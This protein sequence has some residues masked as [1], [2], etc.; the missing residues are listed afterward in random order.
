MS[1]GLYRHELELRNVPRFRVMEYLVE[2]GGVVEDDLAVRGVDWRAYLEAM[3]PV[4]IT[5]IEVRRDR[6]IIEGTNR[7]K[8]DEVK[9]FMRRKTM[10]GGG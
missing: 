8:V 4:R 6:L 1:D 7:A 10:R 3:T 9:N 5:V 2:A